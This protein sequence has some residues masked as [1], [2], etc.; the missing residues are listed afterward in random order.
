MLV[1]AREV[2]HERGYGLGRETGT[3][4]RVQ[5]WEVVLEPLNHQLENPLRQLDAL[6]TVL[7]KIEQTDALEL[8]VRSETGGRPV[9][10]APPAMVDGADMG[11]NAAPSTQF[12]DQDVRVVWRPIRTK[13]APSAD[14]ARLASER[15]ISAAASTASLTRSKATKKASP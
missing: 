6:Q 4:D 10:A 13:G 5:R 15:C 12:S 9:T 11:S 8:L 14:A 1:Q 2:D 7:A 3:F